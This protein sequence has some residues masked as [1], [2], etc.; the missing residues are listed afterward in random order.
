MKNKN[1]VFS[2]VFLLMI[3]ST[4][5]AKQMTKNEIIAFKQNIPNKIKSMETKTDASTLAGQ[6]ERLCFVRNESIAFFNLIQ[7]QSVYY[8]ELKETEM[9]P[10]RTSIQDFNRLLKFKNTT[11]CEL[12]K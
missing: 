5:F 12:I 10:L 11:L 6:I 8:P 9:V 3:C 2:T 4:S 7:E 1:I